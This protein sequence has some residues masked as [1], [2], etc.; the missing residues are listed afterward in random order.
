MGPILINE[1]KCI[2]CGLCVTDCP[3]SFLYLE[4]GK[5]CTNTG[6]CLECGHCYAICP[7]GAVT[8]TNYD[9]TDEAAVPMTELSCHPTLC[10]RRCEAGGQ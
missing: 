3:S 4:N 1:E 9:C 2:G 6:G 7:Q 5:A 8:M 10:S